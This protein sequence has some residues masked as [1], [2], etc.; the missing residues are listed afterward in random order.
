MDKSLTITKLHRGVVGKRINHFNH[1][2][3]LVGVMG[4]IHSQFHPGP[5]YK[6]SP[7]PLSSPQS[8]KGVCS[9]CLPLSTF[10]RQATYWYLSSVQCMPQI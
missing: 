6:F 10:G 3:S 7:S 2:V 8:K 5:V 1:S 4:Q 9:K